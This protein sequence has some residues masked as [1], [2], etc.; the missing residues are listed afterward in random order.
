MNRFG[1]PHP[2]VVE[3][4]GVPVYATSRHGLVRAVWQGDVPARI[5][6]HLP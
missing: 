1:F 2:E 5:R 3:A 4:L 6:T